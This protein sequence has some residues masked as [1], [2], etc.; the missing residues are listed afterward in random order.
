[1]INEYLMLNRKPILSAICLMMAAFLVSMDL[2]ENFKVKSYETE[3]LDLK[4]EQ[5]DMEVHVTWNK[6]DDSESAST[7]HPNTL[8]LFLTNAEHIQGVP[9]P[10]PECC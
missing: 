9:T 10:P 6:N 8:I 3:V 5:D 4:K 2:V 7:Q 1:M